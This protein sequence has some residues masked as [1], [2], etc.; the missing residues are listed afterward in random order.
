MTDP[1]RDRS[2]IEV[3]RHGLEIR[4]RLLACSSDERLWGTDRPNLVRALGA[5]LPGP[6]ALRTLLH[7]LAPLFSVSPGLSDVVAAAAEEMPDDFVLEEHQLLAPVGLVVFGE[8]LTLAHHPEKLALRMEGFVWATF[9]GQGILLVA[10]GGYECLPG[11]IAPFA[12]SRLRLGV[13]FQPRSVESLDPEGPYVDSKDSGWI[14]RGSLERF[15]AMA[16]I[17]ALSFF[18]E[19]IVARG[20]VI[21]DRALRRQIERSG[22][23]DPRSAIVVLRRVE[24]MDRQEGETAPVDWQWRWTVRGHWAHVA[25]GEGR[26]DRRWTYRAAYLKGP[27]DRPLKP[28]CAG[29]LFAVTR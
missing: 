6:A 12:V 24:T 14:A 15:W 5:G 18:N 27:A 8:P 9:P 19:R 17:S 22:G 11:V 20:P 21:A 25:C 3:M 16:V 2:A 10:L 29:S 7:E 1:P 23:L 26:K 28:G 13:P 4:E